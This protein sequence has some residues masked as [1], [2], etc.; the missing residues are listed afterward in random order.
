M[1]RKGCMISKDGEHFVN[2]DVTHAGT[3]YHFEGP[4]RKDAVKAQEDLTYIY[5]AAATGAT[6]EEGLQSMRVAAKTLTWI[7]FICLQPPRSGGDLNG[8]A[9]IG[10]AGFSGLYSYIGAMWFIFRTHFGPKVRA[11][12]LKKLKTSVPIYS[13]FP[14]SEPNIFIL[15][16]FFLI[17]WSLTLCWFRKCHTFKYIG[18]KNE[19][20]SRLGPA[21][22]FRVTCGMTRVFT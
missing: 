1:A 22:V 10:G 8:R 17:Y 6:R 18:S 3:R 7:I 20:L 11:G 19:N 9:P 2:I 15:R 13:F 14:K 4:R 16:W 21:L 5:S 12:P